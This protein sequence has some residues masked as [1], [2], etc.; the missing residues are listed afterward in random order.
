M[1]VV[2]GEALIDLIVSP[3]G[4]M[5]AIP[6]GG[7]YNAARTLGMLGA[8]CTYLGVLADDYFGGLLRQGLDDAN[9]HVGCTEPTSAP[10]SLAV[11]ELS[12]AGAASYRFYLEG[13]SL[14]MLSAKE[15]WAGMPATFTALHVGTLGL[16]VEPTASVLETL[17]ED[18][19]DDHLIMLDPNCRPYAVSDFESFRAR[20]LRLLDNTDLLKV[21][22]DDIDFLFPNG[23][24]EQVVADLTD[25]GGI[26]LYTAGSE[27]IDVFAHDGKGTV[28]PEKGEIVD[29]VG[30][31]DIFG[32]T[33][34]WALLQDGWH[35]GARWGVEQVLPAVRTGSVAAHIACQRA[36][37]EPP[38]L[39][40]LTT[41]LSETG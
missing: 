12:E 3:T 40:E 2:A 33:V 38:R 6:G 25:R 18:S 41:R 8:D 34:L 29:T 15:A 27:P 16:V 17:V 14:P 20:I 13:T 1:I 31:G 7:P 22:D 28:V 26:V 30:A 39:L 19:A 23:G 9:V 21:S 36:G 35:K 4:T 10:S 24:F 32:A 37:A 5:K 11:A